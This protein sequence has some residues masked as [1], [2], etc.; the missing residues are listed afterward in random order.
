[1]TARS[2]R[3]RLPLMER[4]SISRQRTRKIKDG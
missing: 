2:S 4:L 1:L 3:L